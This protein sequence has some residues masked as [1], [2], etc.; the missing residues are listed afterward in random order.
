MSILEDIQS[1][2][3]SFSEKEKQLAT[4]LLR[5]SGT[6]SNINIS[7]LAD[8][9]GT[10]PATITR[11]ARKLEQ[12]SF[13]DLKIQLGALQSK[14]QRADDG[15]KTEVYDYYSRVIENTEKLTDPADMKQIVNL[16]TSA[17]RIFIFGVGSSGLTALELTQRLLRMGLNVISTTDS[18]MM[19]ITSLMA[20]GGDL[21]IGVSTSGETQEVNDSLWHAKENAATII[22]IT[23]FPESTLAKLSEVA[24]I[25]YSSL[26]IGNKRFVNS[27]F[28]IMYQIDVLSTMLLENAE[29]NDK[30]SRTI[31]IITKNEDSKEPEKS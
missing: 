18:H 14:H 22:S 25:A 20:K 3:P 27:Q 31:K 19:L 12:N 8:E 5:N 13:V 9:T 6:V 1:K 2:F 4:Y 21:V 11:F 15:L 28:A 17:P 29:L 10:S 30:M 26:F 24:L 23:C 16:I 7:T